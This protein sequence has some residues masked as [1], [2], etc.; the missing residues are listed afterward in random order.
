MPKLV[1]RNGDIETVLST[2]MNSLGSGSIAVSGEIDNTAGEFTLDDIELYTASKAC[3]PG[4]IKFAELFLI[5]SLDGTNYVDIDDGT[6]EP[7]VT[8][9]VGRFEFRATA[10]S[11]NRHIIRGITIPPDKFKYVISNESG[12]AF[13]SSGNLLR[14]RP[15]V[16]NTA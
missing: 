13:A 1:M 4:A 5:Q 12:C 2:E 11:P 8:M 6:N 14:R 15:W 16:F 9:L 7:S 10:S 3:T